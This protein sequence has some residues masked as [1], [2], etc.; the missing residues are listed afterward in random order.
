MTTAAPT[1][2]SGAWLPKRIRLQCLPVLA[3]SGLPTLICALL[4][5]A[6]PAAAQLPGVPP[7]TQP[8]APPAPEATGS[9]PR[10]PKNQKKLPPGP[11]PLFPIGPAWTIDLGEAPS[12]PAAFDGA[13][14]FVPLQSGQIAAVD[15]D[16]GAVAWTTPGTTRIGLVAEGGRV[17]VV[18]DGEIEAVDAKDGRSLWRV[19][20]AG[21]ITP[22]PAA[23]AGWLIVGLESG[24]VTALN[25]ADGKAVWTIAVGGPL[26][27]PPLIDADRV[28][29]GAPS[30]GL[31]ACEVTTGRVLW[32]RPVEGSVSA[33]L[34]TPGGIYAG[35]TGRW[36]YKVE[37]KSGRVAW[38]W[39]VAGEPIG[40]V[41]D[42]KTVVTLMLDHTMRAF[43]DANGGQSWR[44]ALQYR[45][46]AGPIPAS[47]Q[48]LVAG[49]GAIIRA[50]NRADG[51][52]AGGYAVPALSSPDGGPDQ[53]ETLAAPPYVRT[54]SS[55]FDDAVVMVTQRGIVHLAKRQL[56]PAI[57]PL[58]APPAP[59][60]PAPNPPPGYVPPP[61]TP[62]TDP[63]AAT[64]PPAKATSPATA[65]PPAPQTPG[66]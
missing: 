16:K 14:A 30:R 42:D 2:S 3:G 56:T 17:F 39:R 18:G 51:S 31:L 5:C 41:H 38:R 6:A 46:F 10:P 25:A 59:S 58:T 33:L 53:I 47:A 20:I 45:P 60:L 4:L 32:E 15:L 37:D 63:T 23:K 13:R 43:K 19:P 9:V 52:R 34:A 28:Y 62:A 40:I 54:T 65:K 48:W 61:V 44:E 12:A 27:Q 66:V 57:A 11:W 29:L 1:R 8:E 21:A 22:T 50:Y 35:S 24:D 26:T 64:K 36:F 55:I 7:P 49:H